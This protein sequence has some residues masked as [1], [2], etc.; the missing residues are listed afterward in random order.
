MTRKK[1]WDTEEQ[2]RRCIATKSDPNSEKPKIRE[3]PSLSITRKIEQD[4]V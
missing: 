3:R 1:G 4:E 2:A